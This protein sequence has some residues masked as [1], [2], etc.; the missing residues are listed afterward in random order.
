M[1]NFV[2]PDVRERMLER[3]YFDEDEDTWKVAK[4]GQQPSRPSTGTSGEQQQEI[5]VKLAPIPKRPVISYLKL[6]LILRECVMNYK[7]ANS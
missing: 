7:I 3:A 4:L 5:A 1:E 2:P 6:Q